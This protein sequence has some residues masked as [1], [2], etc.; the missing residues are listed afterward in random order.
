MMS[1]ST[2][3]LLGHTISEKLSKNNHLLSKAQVFPIVC[4]A[5]LQDFLTGAC[6]EP[7]EFIITKSGE[8]EEKIANPTHEAWVALDQ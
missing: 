1:S 3:L 8:K 7:E 2:N 4:G 6:K 5:R